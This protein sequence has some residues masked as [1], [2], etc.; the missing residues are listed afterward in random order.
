MTSGPPEIA[1]I[2]AEILGTGLLSIRVLGWNGEAVRCAA[3]ADHVHNLP[4]LLADDHAQ[5]LLYYWDVERV[6]FRNGM[7]SE[8]RPAWEALW[9][10][11][12]PHVEAARRRIGH[13]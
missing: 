9:R 12:E 7:R 6:C 3:E 1:E 13:P 5:G 8:N 2:L 4:G 11:L 10:Q